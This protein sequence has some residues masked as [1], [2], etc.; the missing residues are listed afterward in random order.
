[1]HP[2]PGKDKW[3]SS[4]PLVPGIAG[5]QLPEGTLMCNFS[6]GTAG[7]PG[8]MQYSE[9]SIFLHEFGHLMHHVLGGQNQWA[10]AGGFNVE[11]DFVEAPSQMLE[12][13]LHDHAVVASF[14]KNYQTGETIPA[15]IVNRMNA[16][17]AFGRG[18]WI[19]RLLFWSTYSLQRPAPVS[20]RPGRSAE[21]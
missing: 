13:I 11:G 7:D 1:M 12:E 5:R 18:I 6:G 17:D 2:R 21:G 8:L 4:A 14:A 15:G 16:A 9:I 20:G 10:G 3:F 19:Q